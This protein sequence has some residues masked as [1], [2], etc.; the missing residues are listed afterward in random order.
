MGAPTRVVSMSATQGSAQ[1]GVAAAAALQRSYSTVSPQGL[2]H[3]QGGGA[4]GG[5]LVS[6]LS[7][8]LWALPTV[9]SAVMDLQSVGA[10]QGAKP[11]AAA[12]AAIRTVFASLSQQAA[13]GGAS[14]LAS[15]P[16][17]VRETLWRD[18]SAA[19]LL[20][21]AISGSATAALEGTLAG[22]DCGLWEAGGTA[23]TLQSATAVHVADT[24]RCSQC[25]W[26]GTTEQGTTWTIQVQAPSLVPP[27]GS[28]SRPTLE[29]ALASA[30]GPNA[31]HSCPQAGCHGSVSLQRTTQS[32]PR[33]LVASIVWSTNGGAT[34]LD[35]DLAAVISAIQPRLVARAAFPAAEHGTGVPSAYRLAAVVVGRSG[36]SVFATL[37]ADPG[38]GAVWAAAGPPGF[39]A[40]ASLGNWHT[41]LGQCRVARMA[42][43]LLLYAQAN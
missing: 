26:V 1:A 34:I 32:P 13:R 37:V 7:V 33:A 31:R 35:R 2:P 9:R 27:P 19:G 41:A 22:L 10:G 25:D 28:G 15:I 36:A 38:G 17:H 24:T 5:Q 40:G 3:L 29:Q 30:T 42:P 11:K 6:C 4:E 20:R 18:F 39:N 8:A 21:D 16:E 23:G 14:S 43:L 12:A